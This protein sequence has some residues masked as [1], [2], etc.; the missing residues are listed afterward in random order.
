MVATLVIPLGA[1]ATSLAYSS[2]A[3]L[4]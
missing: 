4:A 1:F 2:L 3:R